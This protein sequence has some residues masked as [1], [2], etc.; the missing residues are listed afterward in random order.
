VKAERVSSIRDYA[1]ELWTRAQT[2][3]LSRERRPYRQDCS[4]CRHL[5]AEHGRAYVDL[6]GRAVLVVVCMDCPRH[7]CTVT[8]VPEPTG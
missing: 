2:M 8:P 4:I 7:V 5:I 3:P 1:R 6:P